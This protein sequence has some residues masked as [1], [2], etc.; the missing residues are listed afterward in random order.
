MRVNRP[1]PEVHAR[2]DTTFPPNYMQAHKRHPSSAPCMSPKLINALR[3]V[4]PYIKTN[5]LAMTNNT[6]TSLCDSHR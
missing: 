6:V 3:I 5:H 2:P 4:K 1:L